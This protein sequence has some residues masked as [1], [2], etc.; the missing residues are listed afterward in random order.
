MNTDSVTRRTA[1]KKV[2]DF[3][4]IKFQ[5]RVREYIFTDTRVYP[6][7]SDK[8]SGYRISIIAKFSLFPGPH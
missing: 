5:E 4:N 6:T 3:D 8:S 1:V 7:G 2:V